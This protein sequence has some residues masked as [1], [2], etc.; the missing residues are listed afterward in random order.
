MTR[1]RN[2]QPV[3]LVLVGNGSDAP[4]IGVHE[5]PGRLQELFRYPGETAD[6]FSYRALHHVT[7]TGTVVARLIYQT[8]IH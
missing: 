5:V 1:K 7:G 4:F 8:P 2:N 6:A 3:R